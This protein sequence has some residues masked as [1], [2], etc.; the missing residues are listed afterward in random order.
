MILVSQKHI[1]KWKEKAYN[2]SFDESDLGYKM[3]DKQEANFPLIYLEMQHSALQKVRMRLEVC[4]K[5]GNKL[6]ILHITTAPGRL[7]VSIFLTT[8]QH[9]VP[10]HNLGTLL[11][12]FG[13]FLSD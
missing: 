4:V 2:G 5:D 11:L 12:P 1:I 7:E 9:M 6:V 3:K 10:V 13:H 8:H